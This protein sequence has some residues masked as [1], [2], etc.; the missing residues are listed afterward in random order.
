MNQKQPLVSVII[1]VYNS[2]NY[3][4]RCLDSVITQTLKNIEII[5]INDGSTDNS[6][7]ILQ[8]YA[9]Q[10]VRIKIIDQKNFGVSHSRNLGI[11]SAT[12]ET[13]AFLDS[14]DEMLFNMLEVM[15]DTMKRKKSE[16]V[17]T[18]YQ[19][20]SLN[21]SVDKVAYA[22]NPSSSKDEIWRKVLSCTFSSHPGL[23]LY[24]KNLFKKNQ[25]RFP[26]N[27][28]YEDTASFYQFVYHAKSISIVNQPLYMYH[29]LHGTS[30]SNSITIEHAVDI[31]NIFRQT[32][33]FLQQNQILKPYYQDYLLRIYNCSLYF[34]K[35]LNVVHFHDHYKEKVIISLWENLNGLSHWNDLSF[36]K[37]LIL[38][39]E[40]LKHTQNFSPEFKNMLYSYFKLPETTLEIITDY[41][42]STLGLIQPI[43]NYIKQVPDNSHLFFYGAGTILEILANDLKVKNIHILQILDKESKNININGK[44][45]I[46]VPLEKVDFAPNQPNTVIVS[47]IASAS[48]MRLSLLT[49]YGDKFPLNIIAFDH[50]I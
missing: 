47:S 10:D 32:Y 39:F 35:K 25:L 4:K 24:K 22:L 2:E 27:L 42:R 11:L 26:D 40:T 29:Y 38:V 36:D 44:E 21:N 46:T 31:V 50:E 7:S 15:L 48:E 28:N 41:T 17:L 33:Y 3:L 12:A 43:I 23:G 6:L 37:K 16:I 9:N 49:L 8:Q 1:P 14:D 5:A 45:Y 20:I 19:Y 13:I 34:L 18:H 30:R